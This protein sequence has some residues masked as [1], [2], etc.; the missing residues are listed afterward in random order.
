MSEPTESDAGPT[1]KAP[2]SPKR[3]SRGKTLLV[4]GAV[5]LA[6]LFAAYVGLQFIGGLVGEVL[7]GTAQFG[8]G[9]SGCTLDGQATTFPAGSPLYVVA[10]PSQEVS[11]GEVVT[12]RVLRDGAEVSSE[13]LT[14]DSAI[15]TGNCISGPLPSDAFTP[16]HYRFEYLTGT[17]MLASGEF[18]ITP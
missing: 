8:T 3:R 17:E 15:V 16:A 14:F 13:P 1:E 12:M 10:N 11:A 5:I 2:V 6:A 9:G 4:I 18:D 7:L